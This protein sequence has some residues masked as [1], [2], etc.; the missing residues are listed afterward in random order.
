MPITKAISANPYG[1]PTTVID[2]PNS[3]A[4]AV[5]PVSKVYTTANLP[6]A[7][8]GNLGYIVWVVDATPPNELQY[9]DGSAWI[10]LGY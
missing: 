2:N 7:S 5:F 3:Q 6:A 9:S 4:V 8:S 10:P 1:D